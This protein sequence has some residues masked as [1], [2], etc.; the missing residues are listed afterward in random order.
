[1]PKVLFVDDE[2][3][4][5]EGVRRNLRKMRDDWIFF[6]ALSAEDAVEII[7]KEGDVGFCVT[8]IRMPVFDGFRLLSYLEKK[9]P[10]ITPFVLSGQ[11]DDLARAE[12]QK[13]NVMFFEKPFPAE[14]LTAAIEMKLME[15]MV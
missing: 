8:D 11:C 12:F 2:E 13:R 7:E 14:D 5:L 3:F 10:E 4:I 6:Y 9:H 1:M 15:Q